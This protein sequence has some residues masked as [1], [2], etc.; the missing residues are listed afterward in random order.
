MGETLPPAEFSAELIEIRPQPKQE[1]ALASSADIVIFGG[2]AGSGKTY[3]LLLEPLRHVTINPEFSAIIFRRN[4]THIRMPGGLWSE[5]MKLYLMFDAKPKETTLE[6]R[7]YDTDFD[8]GRR[9]S[10]G[11][12][13]MAHLEHPDKTV[14]DYQGAQIPLIEFDE[15]TH[16]TRFEFFYLLS[17]NRSM[18]G[19]SGY[20]RAS[21]NPDPDSWV[22][23]FLAW[24]IDQDEL[25]ANG[26]PNPEYGYPIMSRSGKIRWFIRS[27]TSDDLIWGDSREELVE[28]YQPFSKDKIE[29]KSVTFIPASIYDNQILLDKD[30]GYLASLKALPMVE[31]V[32]LLGR[33]DRGGNWKIRPAAGLMFRRSWCK[34][35]SIDEIPADVEWV[36]YWDLA[37]T[38][39]T[40]DNDPDWTVGV[41][42]GR[43]RS[44]KKYVIAHVER[45]REDP[46]PRDTT[47]L[48]IAK[49]DSNAVRIGIPQDPGQAGKSQVRQFSIS[50]DGFMIHSRPENGDKITRFGPFSSQ[51]EHGNVWIVRGPWYEAFCSSLEAFGDPKVKHDD[52]ADACSGAYNMFLDSTLG[53]LEYYEELAKAKQAAKDAPPVVDIKNTIEQMAAMT[54]AR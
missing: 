46:G 44:L 6:W 41:L 15:L 21:C 1:F 42:L 48:N 7:F 29:P 5:S 39:K 34:V 14:Y 12:V 27:E 22:A 25:L 37:A 10:A 40:A 17:R 54:G 38:K 16:F 32:R 11:L 51:C 23:E 36:R 45:M 19:V 50:F 28:K 13:K 35:V 9:V 43:I 47:M 26:Q 49:G 3:S 52:D 30:P 24:W 20:V 8:T 31:R 4:N 33:A 18:S 53:L 2:A